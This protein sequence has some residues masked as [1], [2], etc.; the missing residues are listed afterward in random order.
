MKTRAIA[1]CKMGQL[2]RLAQG[3]KT[4][5]VAL[6]EMEKSKVW[7]RAGNR[8]GAESSHAEIFLTGWTRFSG[9]QDFQRK[10]K[11]DP[12]RS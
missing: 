12:E 1:L 9:F 10:Q 3:R 6:Y 4:R 11:T 5:A 2:G 7:P 8:C